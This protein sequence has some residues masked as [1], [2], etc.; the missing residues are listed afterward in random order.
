MATIRILLSHALQR[1]WTIKQLDIPAAFLNGELESEVFVYPPKGLMTKS[2]VLKL[3]RALYGLKETP[4][5]WSKRF[6]K[7]SIKSKMKRSSYDCCLYYNES[8][9]MLIYVDDQLLTGN[10]EV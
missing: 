6:N 7:F 2:K 9:W 5:T 10:E 1:N 4:K 8:V 3:N